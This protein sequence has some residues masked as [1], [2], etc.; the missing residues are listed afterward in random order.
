MKALIL[1]SYNSPLQLQEVEKPVPASGQVL[2][3]V[4]SG[5]L[6]PLDLKIM[7]GQA[8]HAQTK[9]PAIP[10]I[11]VSGIAEAVGKDVSTFKPG[12]EVYGMIG[13]VGDNQG[14]LADYVAADARLLALKPKNLSFHEAA[15][16]PLIFITAWEAM[17]DR[18]NVHEGQKVLVHGGAGGVGHIAV[19]IA[20]AR[21]AEVFATVNKRHFE[22][23]TGYGAVPIDYSATSVEAYMDRYTDGEGFDVILDNVGGK[24]LDDAFAA[25]KRYTGHVVSILGWGSHSLAPLSFRGA[26]YSGVFTLYP[27]LSG[28][29]RSHHGEILRQA[30]ALIEAGMVKPTVSPSSY[31]LET[32]MD[33]YREVA[34]GSAGKVVVDIS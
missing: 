34:A 18:A 33:A 6:N 10:G 9:L 26:T 13:G 31:N 28:N 30:T 24:T 25:V 23:I 27:L 8:G 1:N 7:S 3:K 15:A 19:Q 4:R 21:G 29:G 20:R 5:G 17:V 22:L 32:V 11:D 2:I 12:D 14:S 16:L